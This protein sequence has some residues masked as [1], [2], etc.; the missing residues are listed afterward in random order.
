M[1]TKKVYQTALLFTVIFA[2]LMSCDSRNP[3]TPEINIIFNSDNTTINAS[4]PGILYTHPV[5]NSQ[6]VYIRLTGEY[7]STYANQR[8]N[9]EYNDAI[10][11]VVAGGDAHYCTTDNTGA[12]RGF[13]TALSAGTTDIRFYLR[14]YADVTVTKTLTVLHPYISEMT[15]TITSVVADGSTYSN[16]TVRITPEI[17]NQQI[18]FSTT[19]GDLM[20]SSL[21]T[22]VLGQTTTSITSTDIGSATITASMS[23]AGLPTATKFI[24]IDFTQE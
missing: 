19:L 18:S 23:I 11:N 7:E 2:I 9:I 6:E 12:V 10:C 5:F 15:A 1:T 24:I 8:I 16:I 14:D 3:S 20:H 4:L 17:N 22:N 21:P 13:I